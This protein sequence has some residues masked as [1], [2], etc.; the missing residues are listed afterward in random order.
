MR[1]FL[2]ALSDPTLKLDS[3]KIQGSEFLSVMVQDVMDKL[4]ATGLFTSV[5][6]ASLDAG[7]STPRFL[8]WNE[9]GSLA[10]SLT[11]D[12]WEWIMQNSTSV[13]NCL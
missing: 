7:L 4:T 10:G 3:D 5:S 8:K 13:K 9:D 1:K 2:N 11:A 6:K 12:E